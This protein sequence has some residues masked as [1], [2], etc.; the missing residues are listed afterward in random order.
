MISRMI[1]PVLLQLLG[2]IIILAE[3]IL[4]SAGI[5]TV[6]A[7]ALFTYSLYLVF[8]TVSVTAGFVLLAI[9]LVLIPVLVI[10]GVKLL[11]ISPVTLK[12]TLGKG[13]GGDEED[14]FK[15]DL[16]GTEGITLNDLRPAGTASI[17]GKRCD[18]VSGGE[19]I[20]KNTSVVV[21]ATDGN[22]IVVRK[23]PSVAQDS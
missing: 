12:T 20:A 10:I 11:A 6:T 14:D 19:Y 22:R 16:I 13:G 21:T 8:T 7:I 17:K 15:K 1:V 23:K 18:V 5:L 4:P 3:F 9:D 2:V